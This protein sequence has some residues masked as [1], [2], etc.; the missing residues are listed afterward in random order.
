MFKLPGGVMIYGVLLI[1]AGNTG[2]AKL[3][4]I[5]LISFPETT[6]TKKSI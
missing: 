5:I 1:I 2:E 6:M 4:S 3:Q